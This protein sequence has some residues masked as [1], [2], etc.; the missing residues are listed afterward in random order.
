MTV[1]SLKNVESLNRLNDST[2]QRTMNDLKFTF[3]Q[4]FKNPGFT[5]VSVLALA[6]GMTSQ[7]RSRTSPNNLPHR[8]WLKALKGTLK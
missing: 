3:R 6:V 8:I 2:I 1:K 5:A 7:I 4:L